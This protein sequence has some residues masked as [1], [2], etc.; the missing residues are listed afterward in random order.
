MELPKDR[1]GW[2]KLVGILVILY[3]AYR[4]VKW[5]LPDVDAQKV[6]EDVSGSL[7]HWT[8]AIVGLFAFLETG[9]FVGLIAPGET[10]VVLAGA[11]AG[12]GETSV[13]VTIAIVWASAFAGDSASY[14]LGNK[15]GRN[16]VLEHGSKVRLS[17]E[18]FAQ[19][20]AYFA[21]HGGKTILIGRFIGLVRALAPF[22]AGSSGMAYR[23]MAP[24]SVL[25]TGLWATT[26]TLLGFYASKNIDAVLSGSEHALFFFALFVAI[27]VGTTVAVRF[28]RVPENRAKAAAWMD[29]R[30]VFRNVIAIGRRLAP[31][32]R[33]LAGRLTPG[34]LGLEFTTAVAILAVGSF[35]CIG[36]GLQLADTPAPTPGDRTAIDL[37]NDIR[38]D[39]LTSIAKVITA[40]GSGVAISIVAAITAVWLGL[41]RHWPEFVVLIVAVIVLLFGVDPIKDA[42]DR[43]RPDGGLVDAPGSSFPSGH[44][45]HSV[46]YAWIALTIALRLRPAMPRASA[47]VTAGLVT[48]AL[49]GLSRIYL[50]VHYL[51]DVIGGWGFG[52]AVFAL[53]STLALL[54]GYF[55][56]NGDG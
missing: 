4:G 50:G 3:A 46:V 40:L 35:L 54:V 7:G 31:Q 13:I 18:R 32:G 16:F 8:Y 23:A 11:V 9:A 19:V 2:L 5:A 38:A 52:I 42:V 28:L 55:R 20:E 53:L 30:P 21:R 1:R 15:L 41:R 25:G 12:Q 24:Y 27:V 29:E 22:I 36:F 49:I 14:L 51:S 47:L 48:A 34:D 6:L 43:P 37:V 45:A 26:F 33:F 17:R 10:V 56:Q 44:A 39:W